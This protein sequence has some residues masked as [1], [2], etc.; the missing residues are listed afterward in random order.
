LPE[1]DVSLFLGIF[2][3]TQSDRELQQAMALAAQVFHGKPNAKSCIWGKDG[4]ALYW[5]IDGIAT[6]HRTHSPFWSHDQQIA[7]L[8]EGKI[9]NLARLKH[10]LGPNIHWQTDDTSE[11]LA[12]LYN[13]NPDDFLESING[14]FAFVLWDARRQKLLLGRDRFGVQSL[15]YSYQQ[16]KLIFGTSL[17]SLLKTGWIPKQLNSQVVLEYL[18]YC[19][20]P[21]QQT[22]IETVQKVPASHFLSFD[23]A[24][25]NLHRYWN[26]S[27]AEQH[28]KTEAQ[29]CEE[30]PALMEDAVRIR[31]DPS[32]KL[33]VF[34]S[35]GIDSSSML[36]L[37]S[38]YSTE[39]LSTFSFRCAG[40]SYDESSFARYVAQQFNTDHTE[41]QYQPEDLS[42][43][44]AIVQAMD[45]PF[46]DIGI[47][48]G[49]YL[50]GKT[51]QGKVDYIFSGEGGDELFGGHP[52]YTADKVAALVDWV[53][54]SLSH[55]L[56]QLL[57][58]IPD[59]DQKKNLQ[60]KLKR[61]AYSLSFSPELLSHRWRIYYTPQELQKLCTLDFL[62]QCNLETLFE[63]MVQYSK[64]ADGSDGLSRSLYSDYWTLV[65]F[66]LRRLE[67]LRSLG[68]DNSLPLLDYRLVEYA[69][70]IPSSLKLRGF[71]DTKYIYKQA[72]QGIVPDKILFDRPK[73]GHSVPMKNWLRENLEIQQWMREILLDGWLQAGNLFNS[74]FMQQM[75]QEHLCKTHNHSHRLWSLLVLQL[76]ISEHFKD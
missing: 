7:V 54:R 25:L 66:Y 39:P 35:G 11:V 27:F 45:E 60:V 52:V 71:S 58:K 22:F 20:N 1:E 59:S 57:Q 53:P 36:S 40:R 4:I 49:T 26:L 68:V 41:V 31:I 65:N 16:D 74:A 75:L 9:Y 73:L 13:C 37:A 50:L 76:W 28:Q 62:C 30:I 34:L 51:A 43:I 12:Y 38:R 18:L 61:F 24:T 64:A 47:E 5:S 42:T 15:F 17:R 8:F 32:R 21:S 67:L 44:T 70:K 56:M 6:H 23:G 10:E 72:L 19:Y 33:G 48:I 46:C 3:Q 63:S 2:D 69:A 55:P 14:K 29:Y